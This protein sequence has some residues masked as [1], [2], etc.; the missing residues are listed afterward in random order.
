MSTLAVPL[1]AEPS[2][3]EG[4]RELVD[5]LDAIVWEGDPEG[6]CAAFVSRRTEELLGYPAKRWL[7]EPDFWVTVVHPEDR[8]G[9]V[10]AM[11]GIVEESHRGTLEY[12]FI[13][14]DGRVVWVRNSWQC[15]RL[16]DGR[17]RMRGM[18]VDIT[19]Q[20][21]AEEELRSSEERVRKI[22]ESSHDAIL[23]LD[24]NRDRIID[25][26]PRACEMLGYTRPEL[27][28]LPM[29]QIHGPDH[30]QQI[31]LIQ[32]VM[33]TGRGHTHDLVCVTRTGATIPSEI[34][35]SVLGLPG[36]AAIVAI[37]RDIRERKRM[38]KVQR[39]LGDVSAE[40]AAT[41]DYETTLDRMAHLVVPTVADG[42]LV[43]VVESDAA[44]RR[45]AVAHVDPVRRHVLRSDVPESTRRRSTQRPHEIVVP[46]VSRKQ[47]L[48][49]LTLIADVSRRRFCEA[50]V[51]LA[52]GLADRCAHAIENARLYRETQLAVR[53]REEFLAA[54]SHE[55]RTPLHHI[56]AFVSSLR[57]PDINWDEDTRQDF[58]AEIE[59]E[60]D[61]LGRLIADLLDL[62]RVESGGLDASQRQAHSPAD[63]VQGGL[64]RVR[65]LLEGWRL[66]VDVPSDLPP[67]HVD[68][69]QLEGVVANLVEN[70]T[71]YAK[72]HGTIQIRART[73]AGN[74]ELVVEDDGPGIATEHLEM[75]FDK[76]FRVRT[77]EHSAIPGTGLGLAICRAVVRGHGGQIRAENREEGGAR[78]VIS[79]P[80]LRAS[81]R[82]RGR[83]PRRQK[84]SP[85]VWSARA[86]VRSV[87][88][89]EPLRFASNGRADLQH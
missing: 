11:R 43:D 75:V 78:F 69:A 4:F 42:C 47:T 70:A 60:A 56:K 39:L 32:S 35:A 50:D 17:R 66:I 18:A 76:F 36:G 19:E 77:S 13:A 80:Q 53:V 49:V 16:P 74:I 86:S 81:R 25:C 33:R 51:Q 71:K 12:R 89:R 82:P 65:G 27:L 85:S 14:A 10:A 38:E 72:P 26:N 45:V 58:L 64:D 59:R 6:R 61:R 31:A 28:A 88:G 8:D 3:D 87:T 30:A 46:I 37:I 29:S 73:D 7:S 54:T 5:G 34:S 83:L 44:I 79:L 24:P 2:V 57:L 62:S 20:R 23:I 21:R 84:N 15:I 9:V 55:L 52:R 48:G 68:V 63:L 41:L 67:V 40:L 22:F 1:A